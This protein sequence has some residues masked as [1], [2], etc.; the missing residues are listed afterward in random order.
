MIDRR[1][2]LQTAALSLIAPKL[3]LTQPKHID[4]PKFKLIKTDWGDKYQI[5]KSGFT[6]I[7]HA[8]LSDLRDHGICATSEMTLIISQTLEY[9]EQSLKKLIDLPYDCGENVREFWHKKLKRIELS[10]TD[11][12]IITLFCH[13][14]RGP[15][16][17]LY[18]ENT[19]KLDDLVIQHE[20]LLRIE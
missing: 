20:R 13:R 4:I 12:A 17:C 3:S 8:D 5:S 9:G 7:I 2:F 1:C 10:K 11:K 15:H 16:K 18:P 19:A 14:S 6:S